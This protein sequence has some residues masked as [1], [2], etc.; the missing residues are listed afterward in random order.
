M[1]KIGLASYPLPLPAKGNGKAGYRPWNHCSTQSG[2]SQLG[3]PPIGV[4]PPKVTVGGLPAGYEPPVRN[5]DRVDLS[6]IGRRN[7][8][9]PAQGEA[10][11]KV[12]GTVV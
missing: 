6:A 9:I 8:H 4:V 7:R 5:V 11:L 10:T 3:D 1:V 12:V 2:R